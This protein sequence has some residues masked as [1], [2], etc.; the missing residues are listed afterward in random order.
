[1]VAFCFPR[2]S[3]EDVSWMCQQEKSRPSTG[4]FLQ[5]IPL[6]ILYNSGCQ[7]GS[8]LETSRTVEY[9]KSCSSEGMQGVSSGLYKMAAEQTD[10]F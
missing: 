3:L 8:P 10:L 7:G 6:T 1:M 2:D 5:T 9:I 4:P